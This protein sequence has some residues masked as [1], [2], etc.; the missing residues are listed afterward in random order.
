MTEANRL[1]IVMQQPRAGRYRLDIDGR[2]AIRPAS[3]G[4]I[5]LL[6][7]DLAGRI[8]LSVSWSRS[9][10]SQ[11]VTKQAE[12]PPGAAG[13]SYDLGEEPVPA[14]DVDGV[15]EPVA[16]ASAASD[17][18]EDR[19]ARVL[20]RAAIDDRGRLRGLARYDV[21]AARSTLRLRLPPRT[22]LFDVLVDGQDVDA[23]PVAADAWDVQLHDAAW[24]RSIMVV[25]SSDLDAALGAG[26]LIELQPPLIENV[27]GGEVLWAIDAPPGRTLRVADTARLLD[28]GSWQAALHAAQDRID[29]AFSHALAG[30]GLDADRLRVFAAARAA[31]KVTSLE[32]A[33]EHAIES[34]PPAMPMRM[35]AAADGRVTVRVVRPPDA[36]TATRAAATIGLAIIAAWGWLM[37]RRHGLT[38][39]LLRAVAAWFL[40]VLLIVAGGSW[41]A[42]LVPS[43]PGWLMLGG[44]ATVLACWYWS[45]HAAAARDGWTD[46]PS[47]HSLR[48]V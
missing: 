21:I 22:R 35:A 24:P 20:V 14:A 15:Q 7:A 31:G 26:Q 19:V 1:T 39:E 8:P 25:F 37:S 17:P 29:A 16:P 18:Q 9:G 46:Y 30:A 2:L 33:W 40:P 44:G 36:S 11:A 47:T 23:R 5:P 12:V 45:R 3:R 38:W 4:R 10:G 48:E 43:L 13:P 28:E 6:R 34:P 42:V 27:P 41:A 32:R